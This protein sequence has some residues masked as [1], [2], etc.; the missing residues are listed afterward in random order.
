MLSSGSP[1]LIGVAEAGVSSQSFTSASLLQE[2]PP[3]CR[4]LQITFNSQIPSA[5]GGWGALMDVL[6]DNPCLQ[7]AYRLAEEKRLILARQKEV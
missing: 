4:N 2:S 1:Q 6:K 3:S 5:Q 7:K